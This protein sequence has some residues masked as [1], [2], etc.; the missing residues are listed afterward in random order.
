VAKF[1]P[2]EPERWA[3]MVR[4]LAQVERLKAEN[5]R[6][7]KAGDELSIALAAFHLIHR[8]K[9][10]TTTQP[11]IIAWNAAKDGTSDR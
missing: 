10:D 3:E 6:L 4:A 1:I 5:E 9:I 2:V 7:R 8:G 11:D